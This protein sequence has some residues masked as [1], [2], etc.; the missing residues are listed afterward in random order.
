[1]FKI[2]G[3][4]LFS[5][6][7]TACLFVSCKMQL[8]PEANKMEMYK[9]VLNSLSFD[10]VYNANGGTGSMPVSSHS[11][12]E[13]VKISS[14]SF[15]PPIGKRFNRWNTEEDGEGVT[16]NPDDKLV[17]D[18]SDVNLYAIWIDKA[19]HSIVYRNTMNVENDNP[20]SFYES[21]KVEIKPITRDGYVFDGWFRNSSYTGSKITGWEPGTYTTDLTLWAKWSLISFNVTYNL[22]GGTYNSGSNPATFNANTNY[23]LKEPTREGYNFLGWY[24]SEGNKITKLDSSL[25]GKDLELTARYNIVNYTIKYH[26]YYGTNDPANLVTYTIDDEFDLLPAYR[27]DRIFE[28]WYID[29]ERTAADQITKISKGTTGNLDIYSKW[30]NP[31]STAYNVGDNGVGSVANW[32]NNEVDTSKTDNKIKLGG[33]I[34]TN[35]L[36]IL[37]N[38]IESKKQYID[39]IDLSELNVTKF[40]NS[41]EGAGS[42]GFLDH[43]NNVKKII[44]P[45]SLEILSEGAFN[46]CQNLEE[47][48]MHEYVTDILWSA[49]AYCYKLKEVNLPDSV[50]FIA[51][52]AF[53]ECYAL[54]KVNISKNS[55]LEIIGLEAFRACNKLTEFYFPSKLTHL[56]SRGAT[57]SRQDTWGGASNPGSFY[58]CS[59]LTTLTFSKNIKKINNQVFEGCN[60][61]TTINF[62]GTPEEWAAVEIGSNNG[63]LLSATV[64]YNYVIP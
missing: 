13:E 45:E 57:T 3:K 38:A 52:T 11:L 23:V 48:Y 27:A 8:D 21:Q 64:N 63:S 17:I 10:L 14:S 39:E 44:L 40:F 51:Q 12:G 32:I 35:E 19:A 42:G 1:M 24:D 53:Y 34:T 41:G 18:S 4:V 9:N 22:N 26:L 54:E 59:G 46:N 60:S 30:R 16:Y 55:N 2:K 62:E 20:Y 43:L 28:G 49:F 50:E 29:S 25:L 37:A 6:L 58:L 7:L 15:T 33:D 31:V 56:D 5:A 47:I 36:S 61:I